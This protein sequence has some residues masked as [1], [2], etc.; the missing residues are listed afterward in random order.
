M[1]RRI[2]AARFSTIQKREGIKL[3]AYK[4]VAGI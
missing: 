3:T 4:E 2:N 1:T